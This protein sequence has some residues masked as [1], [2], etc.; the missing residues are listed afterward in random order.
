[1]ARHLGM[2]A[3]YSLGQLEALLR[4]QGF[5]PERHVSALYA[6][7]SQQRF[8]LRMA[9]LMEDLGRHLPFL[10]GGVLMVEA[11]KQVY[12]PSRRWLRDVV[13]RPLRVL[14]GAPQPS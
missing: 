12:A 13:R 8:W 1:M 4:Q 9:P 10:A 3:P 5:T 7:P 2:A 11:S 6:T 14:E